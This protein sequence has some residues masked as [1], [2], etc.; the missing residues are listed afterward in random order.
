MDNGTVEQLLD[1]FCRGGLVV[2]CRVCL[3]AGDVMVTCI[4]VRYNR[5]CAVQ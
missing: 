1:F 3:V 2:V 5:Y 4:T